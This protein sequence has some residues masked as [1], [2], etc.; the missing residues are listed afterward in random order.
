MGALTQHKPFFASTAA[1]IVLDSY[2]K[3]TK[4]GD[5]PEMGGLSAREREIIQLLAEGKSNKEVATVLKISVKTAE[6]HR[7]NV[8]RKLGAHSLAEL[9][10][11]AI[12]NR[13]IEA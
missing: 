11:Y 6:T 5:A 9:V 12:R 2:L 1:Q 4:H 10:R 8:M 3:D 7:T 13:I